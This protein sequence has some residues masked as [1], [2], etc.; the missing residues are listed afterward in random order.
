VI[1]KLSATTK[2][3]MAFPPDVITDR[4][5]R[6]G[7]STSLNR[8]QRILEHNYIHDQRTDQ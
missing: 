4:V 6:F 8:A 1:S 5:R 7:A 2:T 3:F